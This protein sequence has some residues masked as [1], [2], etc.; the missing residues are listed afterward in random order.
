MEAVRIWVSIGFFSSIAHKGLGLARIEGEL[1]RM[2]GGVIFSFPSELP[3]QV[4][5]PVRSH[6][7]MGGCLW[8]IILAV[9]WKAGQG[10]RGGL[11]FCEGLPR[12]LGES[13][14]RA[15][16]WGWGPDPPRSVSHN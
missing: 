1:F 12:V 10:V 9:S 4:S 14:P 6:S 2:K 13:F 7:R 8:G 11:I 16:A 3:H 5:L 15:I